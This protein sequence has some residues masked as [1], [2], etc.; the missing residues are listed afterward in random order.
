MN[1]GV[2]NYYLG[3]PTPAVDF[4]RRSRD[5]YLQLGD[6]RRVAE[7]D[8]DVAGLQIDYGNNPAEVVRALRNARANLEKM[9][10]FNFQ[11][12][13]M[14]NEAD[15]SRFAGRIAE[16]RTLLRSALQ[17]AREKQLADSVRALRLALALADIQA[18][19]Y[20]QA[21]AA[22]QEVVDQDG[23][24]VDA[25]IALGTALTKIGDLSGAKTHLD[26]AF[27]NATQTQNDRLL[28]TVNARLGELAYEAG[29][30]AVA[31]QH[32]DDAIGSWTDPLPNASSVEARCYRGL[33]KSLL[34]Q[35]GRSDLDAGIAD[36]KRARRAP[37]EMA[38]RAQLARVEVLAN[39]RDAAVSALRD[40]PEES[41]DFTLGPE[42]RAQV[43]F[44]RGRAIESD[45]DGER[46]SADAQK[47]LETLRDSLPPSFRDLFGARA[48]IQSI[49]TA[50]SVRSHQ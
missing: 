26:E 46:L 47:R 36:A 22:L 49:L 4:Y 2:I 24:D 45:S 50:P 13:A 40:V 3:H 43:Q 44:W 9:G 16:A 35:P 21:R 29:Q 8:V 48:D 20:E 15:T 30:P 14:Q 19:D 6:E 11:L 25:Q 31:L 42:L 39:R 32:F 38:C 10:H 23:S 5:V 1:L 12:M 17:I 28:P 37:L 33:Q 27:K 34:G 18:G 41:A 7:I